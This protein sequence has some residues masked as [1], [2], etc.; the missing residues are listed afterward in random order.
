[1]EMV[2]R[3]GLDC[4]IYIVLLANNVY[5]SKSQPHVELVIMDG[6]IKQSR[7]DRIITRCFLRLRRPRG[8]KG[9]R[10]MFSLCYSL[11]RKSSLLPTILIRLE[12]LHIPCVLFKSHS[13]SSP[14]CNCKSIIHKPSDFQ[15]E[16]CTVIKVPTKKKEINPPSIS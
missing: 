14:S 10:M 16:S 13:P 6:A 15:G 5:A 7:L 2:P 8:R 1:M 11:A 9:M 3:M 4:E 12:N